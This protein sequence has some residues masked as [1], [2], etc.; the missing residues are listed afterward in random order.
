MSTWYKL[1]STGSCGEAI[2]HLKAGLSNS[3]PKSPEFLWASQI[4][5][6]ILQAR[7]ESVIRSLFGRVDVCLYLLRRG[8]HNSIPLFQFP[9]KQQTH[10]LQRLGSCCQ[11]FTVPLLQ[12]CDISELVPA[13]LLLR[14]L[15]KRWFPGS[16]QTFSRETV[17]IGLHSLS[18]TNLLEES[19]V[20]HIENSG[21][22]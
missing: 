12:L 17:Q 19:D 3:V 7:L 16:T 4:N 20:A 15:W 10:S 22:K 5:S 9:S 8:L 11:A 13:I 2:T 21:C 1:A 6:L 14:G 18:S